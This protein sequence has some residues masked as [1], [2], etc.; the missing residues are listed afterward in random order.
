M[1]KKLEQTLNQWHASS[2]D[3][4]RT[5]KKIKIKNT[6]RTK[7]VNPMIYKPTTTSYLSYLLFSYIS[8][9]NKTI[10]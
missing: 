2:I 6:R 10:K 5:L 8:I 4:D 9:H 7:T 1:R 3:L